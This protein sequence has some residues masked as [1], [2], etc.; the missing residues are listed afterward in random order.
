MVTENKSIIKTWPSPLINLEIL[1][2]FNVFL[3]YLTC[4]F[5]NVI[6]F[7]NNP[8]EICRI[9]GQ[10]DNTFTASD[11]H[12][13]LKSYVYWTVHHCDSWRIRDQLYVT[14]YYVLFHFF[15]AQHVSDSNT[16]I[17]R[18]LLL[19]YCIHLYRTHYKRGDTIEKSQAAD[20]GYINLLTPNVNRT[21]ILQ[22]CILY[23]YS[24]NIGTEHF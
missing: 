20:D 8:N 24:T 23:I 3:L 11:P 7:A 17:I 10:V 5:C 13:W 14:C 6:L 12:I 9:S 21:A 1:I 2:L 18:S 19:F 4:N 15:Y 16:S 22:S